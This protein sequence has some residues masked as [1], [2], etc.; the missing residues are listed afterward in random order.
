MAR[1]SPAALAALNLAMRSIIK[2]AHCGCDPRPRASALINVAAAGRL[3]ADLCEVMDRDIARSPS[4]LPRKHLHLRRVL[5]RRQQLR[6]CPLLSR[7][8]QLGSNVV[9]RLEY[10][11]AQMQARVGDDDLFVR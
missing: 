5:K 9:Q 1:G 2:S 6:D 8:Q 7:Q 11:A 4:P 3:R 10:E